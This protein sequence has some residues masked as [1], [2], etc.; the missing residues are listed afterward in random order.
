MTT[1]QNNY[2]QLIV[3]YLSKQKQPFSFCLDNNLYAMVFNVN[4]PNGKD[5]Q[6]I[7][8]E[9]SKQVKAKGC[10]SVNGLSVRVDF[11]Y[12]YS[13]CSRCGYKDSA[14]KIHYIIR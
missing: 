8:R 3:Q 6:A 2:F 10:V 13:N 7:G 12:I 11:D 14:N 4:L 9:F 1:Q 5:R